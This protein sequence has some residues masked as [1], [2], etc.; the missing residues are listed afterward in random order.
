MKE[1]KKTK[2]PLP[3]R[4]AKAD[5]KTPAKAQLSQEFV[6]SDDDSAQEQSRSTKPAPK[7]KTTIAIHRPDGAVKSTDKSSSKTSKPKKKEKPTPKKATPKQV[8][9]QAHAEELSSSEQSDADDDAPTRDIQTNLAGHGGKADGT[10]TSASDSDSELSLDDSPMPD[11]PQSAQKPT[12]PA[13][14]QSHAVDFR[15]A[16]TYIPPKGF[17]AVPCNDKTT[18]K[19]THMF[20][21][22]QGKQIWHITAPAGLSMEGLKEMSIYR[23]MDGNAVL[24]HKGTAYGFSKAADT[25]ESI[26]QIMIP[27]KN[28]YSAGKYTIPRFLASCLTLPL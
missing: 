25:D 3:V 11:A 15:P 13:E 14:S 5:P 16:Q 20:N 28:G 8:V 19:S 21:N 9:T 4:K 10:S 18:S 17:N 26:C 7:P 27:H 24:E 22:L 23:A 12:R 6:G 1:A 2:V